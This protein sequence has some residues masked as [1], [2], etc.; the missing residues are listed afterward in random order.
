[1][2]PI[3]FQIGPIPVYS[4]GLM[5]GI[6]FL[7][8]DF[9]LGKEFKRMRWETSYANEMIILAV[10][11]G[12]AGAKLWFLAENFTEFIE[13]PLEMAFSPGGL[14]WY[15]G[16][17]L[18]F[19][20]LFIYV[21]KKKLPVLQVMDVLAPILAL[22]HGIGRLGCHLSGD[23][24]YGIPTSLPWGTN[25]AN[26]TLKPHIALE[27]FF[28]RHPELA[29]KFDYYR[30]TGEIVGRDQF[31]VITAFDEMIRLHPTPVYEFFILSGI[32]AIL[33]LFR[34]KV[35]QP[36]KIFAFYLILA[37]MERFSI[38]FIRLNSP[39]ILGLS[40]AQLISII[41]IF[42]GIYMLRRI[43]NS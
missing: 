16:F 33:W 32:F 14:T 35:N 41:F 39:V 7:L 23:G 37:G 34:K 13:S 6:A 18:T 38:E 24:D 20:V 10:I 15:G 8:A 2:K 3:L 40:E 42:A 1:M 25:Y 27:D 26:G 36:G 21:K 19:F 31:G 5:M 28:K 9:L 29:D 11:S 30:L 22:G 17:L 4:Y 12:I 43:K